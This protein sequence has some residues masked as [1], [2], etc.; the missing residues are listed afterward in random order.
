MERLQAELRAAKDEL[1][2]S[3][4]E[5]A[6][7]ERLSTREKQ[8][9]VKA[10]AERTAADAKARDADAAFQHALSRL[11]RARKELKSAPGTSSQVE[12]HRSGPLANDGIRPDAMEQKIRF[13]V[14]AVAG[15]FSGF[16]FAFEWGITSGVVTLAAIG[17]SAL[18]GGV[19][20]WW[21]GDRYWTR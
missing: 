13:A 2:R 19:L 4:T 14:G 11:E 8:D 10:E 20:A 17:G 21:Y 6:R 3:R 18:I 1:T 15:G 7:L 16:Y 9:R 12:R 5:M